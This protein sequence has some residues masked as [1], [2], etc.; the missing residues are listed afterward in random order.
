MSERLCAQCGEPLPNW[1]SYCGRCGTPAPRPRGVSRRLVLGGLGLA[2][3][4]AVGGG[5]AWWRAQ[6]QAPAP[7]ASVTAPGESLYWGVVSSH[8]AQSTVAVAGA[9]TLFD[10]IAQQVKPPQ[11][12]GRY[13][14][15]KDLLTPEEIIFLFSKGCRILVI[16]NDA[17]PSGDHQGGVA[18]AQRAISAAEALGAPTGVSIYADIETGVYA[19]PDWLLG[20]W[21]TM[22]ASRY[23]NPGGFYCNTGADNAS[24]FTT[25]YCQALNSP[26]NQ[27]PDGS[28]RFNP[29]L[30]SSAPRPGCGFDRSSYAPTAPPCAPGS[31]VIWQYALGCFQETDAPRGLCDMDLAN[32]RGYATMWSREAS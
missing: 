5:L 22:G 27:Q 15:G 31:V 3:L 1:A 8:A 14:G 10:F 25:P 29:L 28:R 9:P 7:V 13:I 30:F 32:A 26:A 21:E 2:G 23:A 18:D 20:W 19:N 24:A 11:Y 16:Y 4:A 6:G 17:T 12:W